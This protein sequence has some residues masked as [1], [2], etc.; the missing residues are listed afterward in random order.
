MNLRQQPTAICARSALSVSNNES[1]PR[2]I[3]GQPLFISHSIPFPKRNA[4]PK[5]QIARRDSQHD[6]GYS[7]KLQRVLSTDLPLAAWP[8]MQLAIRFNTDTLTILIHAGK[9]AFRARSLLGMG[10][11]RVDPEKSREHRDNHRNREQQDFCTG[12]S[13]GHLD[14]P[15]RDRIRRSRG[16]SDQS[17][18]DF[19]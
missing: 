17:F 19:N 1:I 12:L 2:A 13:F 8:P 15:E 14:H 9:L 16:L 10:K 4:A 3:R 7:L 5:R 6:L 11:Q 18:E